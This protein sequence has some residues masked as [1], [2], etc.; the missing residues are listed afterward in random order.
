MN[1]RCPRAAMPAGT[2]HAAVLRALALT[3][4]TPRQLTSEDAPLACLQLGVA[5]A[6]A[7]VVWVFGA[8]GGFHGPAGGLYDRLGEA[9]AGDGVASLQ[10]AY[11]RSGDL[12]ACVADVLAG[13]AAMTQETTGPVAL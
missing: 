6:R 9:L 1:R 11:R 2:R 13:V 3:T 7:A 5:A 4:F 10:V 8:G 12:R